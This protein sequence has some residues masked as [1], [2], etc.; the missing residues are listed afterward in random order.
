M[1]PISICNA[2]VWV[3]GTGGWVEAVPGWG[4]HLQ[5]CDCDG[6]LGRAWGVRHGWGR[7][8][9]QRDC[10]AAF[11]KHQSVLQRLLFQMIDSWPPGPGAGGTGVGEGAVF[12]DLKSHGPARARARAMRG[13]CVP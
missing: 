7:K 8:V 3:G 4:R 1:G 9:P 6:K 2:W 5:H 13:A 11:F 12:L 10:L